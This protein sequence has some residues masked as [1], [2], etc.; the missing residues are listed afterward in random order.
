MPKLLLTILAVG[1]ASLVAVGCGGGSSS[2]ETSAGES[3][4]TT[5]ASEKFEIPVKGEVPTR[6]EKEVEA[7]WDGKGLLGPQP[8]PIIPKAP[9]PEELVAQDLIN[10]KGRAAHKGSEI[11]VQYVG[12]NYKTGK[13]FD[14]SWRYGKPFTF[15]LGAG[16]VVPGWEEGLQGME[17]GA[18]RELIIPPELGYGYRR[19]E[20]IPPGSTLVFVV[21]LLSVE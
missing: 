1:C 18:R 14:A 4:A 15:E 20:G 8:K 11:T 7:E 19:Q 6:T 3:E 10:G 9:P 2:S 16:F 17:V 21:D 12:V 5:T 13:E